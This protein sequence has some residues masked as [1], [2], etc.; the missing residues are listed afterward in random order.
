MKRKIFLKRLREGLH[1]LSEDDR[2]DT[3]KFYEDLFD[4]QGI[5]KNEEIPNI[6]NV[7]KVIKDLMLN[8]K[9]E[10]WELEK[11]T[12]VKMRKSIL[13]IVLGIFA[14]PSILFVAMIFC[15]FLAMSFLVLVALYGT[16]IYTII[17]TMF[18][19]MGT[20]T[21]SIS[22]VTLLIGFVTLN[23]GITLTIVEM[24]NKI[25]GI[26]IKKIKNRSV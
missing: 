13:I 12:L 7:E 24:L 25:S 10:Q 1:K 14:M 4:E 5:D 11:K 23:V 26:I 2:E 18:Y 22:D 6:Y 15:I 8:Q 21:Y 19:F 16:S 9:I 20:G 3:I 17:S